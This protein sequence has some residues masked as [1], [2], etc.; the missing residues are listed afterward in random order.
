MAL[1]GFGG[2]LHRTVQDDCLQWLR[3]NRERYGLIFVD[4]PTFSNTKHKKQTF[5]IQRDHE[6]LLRLAMQRLSRNGV[7]IFST[8]FRKFVLAEKIE[9]DFEILEITGQTIPEDFKDS[10]HV[11]RCWQLRH[12]AADIVVDQ[13]NTQEHHAEI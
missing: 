5:D 13:E 1:N 11:H 7:L 8:N 4:P 3:N 9:R 10:R 2:P 12:R 6:L